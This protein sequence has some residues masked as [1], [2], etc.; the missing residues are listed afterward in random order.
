MKKT[1]LDITEKKIENDTFS[2]RPVSKEK[3]RKIETI[4]K[5]VK[6]GRNNSI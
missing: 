2:F 4:I 1:K 6:K 3:L 5:K